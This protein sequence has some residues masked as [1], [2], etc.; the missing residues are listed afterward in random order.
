[1]SYF[2]KNEQERAYFLV[3]SNPNQELSKCFLGSVLMP[4]VTLLL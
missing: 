3:V 4:T 1:M 2:K